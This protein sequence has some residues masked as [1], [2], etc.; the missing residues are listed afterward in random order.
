VLRA[1]AV[2]ALNEVEVGDVVDVRALLVERGAAGRP[3]TNCSGLALE[4]R[5]KDAPAAAAA[6]FVVADG[7]APPAPGGT[8]GECSTR[9]FRAVRPG[10]TQ[11]SVGYDDL[12]TEIELFAYDP[13]RLAAPGDAAALVTLGATTTVT[14]VGGPRA[15]YS[16]VDA[17]LDAPQSAAVAIESL[18]AAAAA[19]STASAP[20][21]SFRLTCLALHEQRLTLRVSKR[22]TPRSPSPPTVTATVDLR[23][24]APHSIVRLSAARAAAQRRA[25]AAVLAGTKSGA[26]AAAA[27]AAAASAPSDARRRGAATKVPSPRWFDAASVDRRRGVGE[28]ARRADDVPAAQRPLDS[29]SRRGAERGGRDVPERVDAGDRVV[30]RRRLARRWRAGAA[31]CAARAHARAERRARARCASASTRAGTTPPRCAP[32]ACAARRPSAVDSRE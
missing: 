29:V 27:A 8:K 16:D 11:I 25:C 21:R 28:R 10:R 12:L 32:P 22:G 19:A 26:A 23:C 7:G 18:P 1:A 4:W 9:R 30:R 31:Q 13:L 24:Q 5:I 15:W 17:Q 2:L 20:R 14:F 6:A 3:F